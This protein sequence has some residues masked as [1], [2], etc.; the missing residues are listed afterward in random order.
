MF[1]NNL[2]RGFKL[3]LGTL[4]NALVSFKFLIFL[5]ALLWYRPQLFRK[6]SGEIVGV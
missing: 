2:T 6:S 1:G 5:Y 4:K 3:Q